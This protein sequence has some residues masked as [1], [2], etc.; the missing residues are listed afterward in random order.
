MNIIFFFIILIFIFNYINKKT[1]NNDNNFINILDK[2]KNIY[3]IKNTIEYNII[4]KIKINIIKLL[5]DN[6]NYKYYYDIL[7]N[8]IN[9]IENNIINKKK[10][11]LLS[12][13]DNIYINLF[14]ND[15]Y[16]ILSLCKNKKN[17]KLDIN[18]NKSLLEIKKV[19]EY[20]KNM[21]I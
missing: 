12:V 16:S 6:E 9:N 2:Y 4:N 18:R 13:Q 8:D 19:K 14:L 17:Q 5:N 1:P 10:V 15:L 11:V 3:I 20:N 7:E 21:Y